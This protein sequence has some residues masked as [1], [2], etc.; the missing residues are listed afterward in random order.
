M[1]AQRGLGLIEDAE[2][3]GLPR[4]LVVI[5]GHRRIRGD[6]GMGKFDVIARV[7]VGHPVAGGPEGLGRLPDRRHHGGFE[8]IVVLVEQQDVGSHEGGV[9]RK[10]RSHQGPVHHHG[11]GVHDRGPLGGVLHARAD[12]VVEA[13]G[14]DRLVR[15]GELCLDPEGAAVHVETLRTHRLK[16]IGERKEASDSVVEGAE[17]LIAGLDRSDVG[18]AQVEAGQ[19]VVGAAEGPAVDGHGGVIGE[20][21]GVIQVLNPGGAR[22]GL[23][24]AGGEGGAV[25]GDP[26]RLARDLDVALEGRERRRP[27][28]ER[29]PRR[30]GTRPRATAAPR[31]RS[32]ARRRSEWRATVGMAAR[33]D[34]S[35]GRIEALTLEPWTS[36]WQPA[37]QQVPSA[38]RA[39][40]RLAC[41]PPLL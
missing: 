40:I 11:V 12:F 1:L 38:S 14:E 22:R 29:R 41:A 25:A 9:G 28:P 3:G 27:G 19:V 23:A 15:L 24:R 34:M 26:G 17:A 35:Q 18:G 39:P 21:L 16:L 37:D 36:S 32:P 2:G 6:G 33:A 30:P 13:E 4:L 31:P 8:D 20:I 5:H 7:V 10:G